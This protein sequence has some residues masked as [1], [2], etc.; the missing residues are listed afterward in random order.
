[1]E[2]IMS[3]ALAFASKHFGSF[4][5]TFQIGVDIEDEVHEQLDQ[6][7]YAATLSAI[8][9][10]ITDMFNSQDAEMTVHPERFKEDENDAKES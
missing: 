6:L 3:S 1:M 9:S 10:N 2:L 4:C 7:A 8:A 5:K